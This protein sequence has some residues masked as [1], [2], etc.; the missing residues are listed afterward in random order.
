MG[1]ELID[2]S[3]D[4]ESDANNYDMIWIGAFLLRTEEL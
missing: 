1:E 4:R 2:S 3:A